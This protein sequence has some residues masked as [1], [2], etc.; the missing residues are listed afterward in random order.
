MFNLKRHPANWEQDFELVALACR[1]LDAAA[2]RAQWQDVRARALLR[3]NNARGILLECAAERNAN[4]AAWTNAIRALESHHATARSHPTG[5]L[6]KAVAHYL[7]FV[8]STSGVEQAFSK[9]AWL[10][11]QRRAKA[12]PETEE[13]LLKLGLNLANHDPTELVKM[14]RRVWICCFGAARARSERTRVDKGIKRSRGEADDGRGFLS[15]A[16]FIAKRRKAA[17][18]AGLEFAEYVAASA[19]DNPVPDVG[20]AWTEAREKERAFFSEKKTGF[21]GPSL[22][23]GDTSTF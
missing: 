9:A 11:H 12:S 4:R 1:D 7:A 16:G 18:Q 21:T 13:S 2:L 6:K 10:A 3:L 14:A 5:T 15:E 22:S 19:N 17:S 20:D 8:A 23:R